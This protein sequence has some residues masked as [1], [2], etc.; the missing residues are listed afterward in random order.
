MIE[1]THLEIKKSIPLAYQN[2]LEKVFT[3][4]D[5]MPWFL[6]TETTQEGDKVEVTSVMY[7]SLF[8]YKIPG[9][10]NSALFDLVKPACWQIIENA[11]LD[12][13]EFLQIR[14]IMQFPV[15]TERTH[16]LIHTDIEDR[17]FGYYTGVYYI[18]GNTDGDTVLFDKTSAEVRK[19]QVLDYYKSFQEI[20][21]INPEK[22]KTTI[23]EGNRYHS[24]TLPTKKTRF[25]LNFSWC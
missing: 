23:F 10:T 17:A 16:N 2:E 12:F 7:H 6:T 13:N 18:N 5:G 20:A 24:S 9:G 8:Y 4:E 19:E 22:G 15:I 25:V 14:A 21:R 1:N 3:G 11:G